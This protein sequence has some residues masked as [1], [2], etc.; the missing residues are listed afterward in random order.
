M[1]RGILFRFRSGTCVRHGRD[2]TAAR[3]Y[4]VGCSVTC[5]TGKTAVSGFV[6]L[7]YI[8]TD[9]P[10]YRIRLRGLYRC[11]WLHSKHGGQRFR[12]P[13]ASYIKGEGA[14]I[15]YS[16]FSGSYTATG[17]ESLLALKVGVP[18]V[19]VPIGRLRNLIR[20][21]LSICGIKNLVSLSY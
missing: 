6:F 10:I 13:A 3:A 14:V 17:T 11:W 7:F 9:L 5:V 2:S 21:A 8:C 4:P 19:L 15:W 1:L 12:D 20:M 18:A 16:K